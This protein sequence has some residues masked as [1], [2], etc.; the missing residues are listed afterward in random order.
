MLTK[1]C[2][3]RDIYHK[4]CFIECANQIQNLKKVF[5]V[6]KK[7]NGVLAYG[8]IDHED[9]FTFEVLTTGKFENGVL[10]RGLGNDEVSMK[11][12][13]SSVNDREIRIYEDRSLFKEYNEKFKTIDTFFADTED[14][15]KTRG[16]REIDS[17]RH[18]DFP[19]DVI[20]Y[21]VKDGL[22]PETVWVRCEKAEKQGVKAKLISEPKQDFGVHTNDFVVFRPA[23]NENGILCIAK[24]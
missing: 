24:L 13:K 11:F 5:N 2:N 10:S 23:K 12:R 3:F 21:L 22:N 16:I 20:I 15:D 6:S 4:V 1:D 18:E 19:D 17:C 14:V 9:G 7:D 8:Y